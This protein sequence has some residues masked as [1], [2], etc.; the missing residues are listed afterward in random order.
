M[1][2][3]WGIRCGLNTFIYFMLHCRKSQQTQTSRWSGFDEREREWGRG[4][5]EGPKEEEEEDKGIFFKRNK[6]IIIYF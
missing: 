1:L 6:I 3:A 5:A 2:L 4:R